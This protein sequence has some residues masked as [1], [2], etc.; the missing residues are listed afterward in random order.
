MYSEACDL[1]FCLWL[2]NKMIDRLPFTT[3]SITREPK[4][5]YGIVLDKD[6]RIEDFRK[7]GI[8]IK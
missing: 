6:E 7:S 2:S 8:Y 4:Y 3:F 1:E 5:F